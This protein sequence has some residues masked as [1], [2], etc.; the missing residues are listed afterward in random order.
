MTPKPPDVEFDDLYQE[1]LLDH[2]RN[3]RNFREIP[4]APCRAAG[5]NPLCGDRV[6]LFVR[7]A[8]EGDEAKIEE[9]AFQGEGCAIS[10]AS[11]SMLTSNLKGK[12][13]REARQIAEKFHRLLTAPKE[14]RPDPSDLGEL[15]AFAGVAEYP[16]RV[17]CATMAWHTFKEAVSSRT[18]P[19]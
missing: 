17:K 13:L 5:Y 1:I 7:L 9:I 8:G 15:E 10:K 11:A 16:M 19:G 18:R 3:P 14:E 12:T 6:Q 2:N 4:D